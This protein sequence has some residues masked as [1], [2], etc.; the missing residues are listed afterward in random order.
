MRQ[1]EI[2]RTLAFDAPRRARAWQ[3]SSSTTW[4]SVGPG[5]EAVFGQQ[6][7][8][9]RLPP[10]P[11]RVQD[12]GRH[13]RH[14]VTFDAFYKHSRIKQYL[15]DGRALCIETSRELPKLGALRLS[16]TA[17]GS[18]RSLRS[19]VNHLLGTGYNANR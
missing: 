13:P 3:R 12:Q 2:S 5:L 16:L 8:R 4:T 15:K 18:T 1:I 11:R 14:D 7:R 17:L 6:I 9:G 10:N 19:R